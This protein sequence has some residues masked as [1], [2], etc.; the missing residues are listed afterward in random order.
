MPSI[1]LAVYRLDSQPDESGPKPV[2]RVTD[3]VRCA[4]CGYELRGL[5]VDQRCPECAAP[6]ANSLQAEMLDFAA[7]EF[8][9]RLMR[10]ALLARISAIVALCTVAVTAVLIIIAIGVGTATGGPPT[11]VMVILAFVW[12]LGPLGCGGCAVFGWWLLTSPDPGAGGTRKDR[13]IRPVLRVGT[14]VAGV[15]WG[16]S[17]IPV[18]AQQ[19][20]SLPPSVYI[21]LMAVI[22][23]ALPASVA[24]MFFAAGPY[25]N[26]MAERMDD[27]YIPTLTLKQRWQGIG[28]IIAI[29]AFFLSIFIQGGQLLLL[30]FFGGFG[31]LIWLFW[32]HQ[33]MMDYAYNVLLCCRD[34]HPK[35]APRDSDRKRKRSAAD[36]VRDLPR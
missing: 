36:L 13:R 22:G 20:M 24:F 35:P 30:S 11:A 3:D 26:A 34:G 6:V 23:I 5:T 8:L 10:G 27:C 33:H 17:C 2:H 32:T 25:M 21:P 29:G 16:L 7:P 14:V 28:L 19:L 9:D 4:R 1:L 15:C 18:A 12:L 31:V